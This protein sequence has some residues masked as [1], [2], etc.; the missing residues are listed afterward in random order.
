MS[1][2]LKYNG[3]RKDN[4]FIYSPEINVEFILVLKLFKMKTKVK[5]IDHKFVSVAIARLYLF[6]IN[7]IFRRQPDIEYFIII[8]DDVLISP[9]F[10]Q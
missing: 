5:K 2:V 8:E 6:I 7:D 10:F 1:A 4:I 9:D 3:G